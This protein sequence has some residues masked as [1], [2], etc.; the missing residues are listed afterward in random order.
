MKTRMIGFTLIEVLIALLILSI[1][2]TA[3]L[4]ASATTIHGTQ[5]LKEKTYTHLVSMQAITL[6]QLGLTSIS[7][8]QESTKSM[9]IA[10]QIWYWHAQLSKTPLKSV[11]KI[12]ITTSK[13]MAGPFNDPI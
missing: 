1:S 6:I 8:N 10:D 9:K 7:L 2:L 12:T 11:Q 13:H 4:K 3:L 5:R